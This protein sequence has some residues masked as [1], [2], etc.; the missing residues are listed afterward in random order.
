MMMLEC[1]YQET[2]LEGPF[3]PIVRGLDCQ[4]RPADSTVRAVRS[5][6]GLLSR[7]CDPMNM[8]PEVITAVVVAGWV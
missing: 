5:R 7:G 4:V 8:A 3:G 1:L 6:W 2:R